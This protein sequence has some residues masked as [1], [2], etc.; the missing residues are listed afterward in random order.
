LNTIIA[1]V[2]QCAC[3]LSNIY[4]NQ[5]EITEKVGTTYFFSTRTHFFKI[6]QFN[7]IFGTSLAQ[8]A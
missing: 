8:K 2:L 7:S 5:P 4:S 6:F 3:S 1:N